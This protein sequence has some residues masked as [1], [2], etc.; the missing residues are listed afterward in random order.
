MQHLK[1]EEFQY[2]WTRYNYN[3]LCFSE[4]DDESAHSITTPEFESARRNY[5]YI[6][7]KSVKL[8]T[9]EQIADVMPGTYKLDDVCLIKYKTIIDCAKNTDYKKLKQF[10][11]KVK[12]EKDC[13]IILAP[14]VKNSNHGKIY[15]KISSISRSFK[16]NHEVLEKRKVPV[17][18]IP[19]YILPQF[20]EKTYGSARTRGSSCVNFKLKNQYFD[21]LTANVFQS[22]S[23]ASTSIVPLMKNFA[24]LPSTLTINSKN[25]SRNVQTNNIIPY[26]KLTIPKNDY[27]SNI[28]FRLSNTNSPLNIQ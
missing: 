7:V 23:A 12:K 20:Y 19:K 8:S 6:L 16:S 2:H 22:N 26:Y 5:D 14:K 18:I 24:E 11:K 9:F 3:I 4:S 1:E 13:K 28:D 25:Y 15:K 10:F 17:M 27:V 21:K